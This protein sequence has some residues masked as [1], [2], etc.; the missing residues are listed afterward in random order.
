MPLSLAVSNSNRLGRLT[1][2]AC[3]SCRWS[4]CVASVGAG[5]ILMALSGEFLGDG[6]LIAWSTSWIAGIIELLV[7]I[8][9]PTVLFLLVR[10]FRD[11]KGEG[12]L[13]QRW[14]RAGLTAT[15]MGVLLFILAVASWGV[16]AAITS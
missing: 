14:T 8:P 3:A 12:N 9:M 6:L 1:D 2:A 15:Y 7:F 4:V 16:M 10:D 13:L 5:C 11:S